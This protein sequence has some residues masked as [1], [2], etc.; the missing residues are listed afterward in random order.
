MGYDFEIFYRAGPKNR[1]ADAL[2]RILTEAQLN[3]ISVPSLVD[4]SVVEKGDLG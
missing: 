3:V 1:A 4:V 2:S